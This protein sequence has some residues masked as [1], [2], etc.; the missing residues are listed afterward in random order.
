MLHWLGCEQQGQEVDHMTA[1][2]HEVTRAELLERRRT[3]LRDLGIPEDELRQRALEHVLT[4]EERDTMA[5]LEEIDF[6]LGDDG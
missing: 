1:E 4:P 2:L 3:A 5:A 6:L